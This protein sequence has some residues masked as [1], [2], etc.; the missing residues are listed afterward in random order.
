M[1]VCERALNAAGRHSVQGKMLQERQADWSRWRAGMFAPGC[2]PKLQAELRTKVAE[3]QAA[4]GAAAQPQAATLQQRASA[5]LWHPNP[6]ASALQSACSMSCP[7]AA[8]GL[9]PARIVPFPQ[10][11]T[12]GDAPTAWRV[13]RQRHTRLGCH[14]NTSMVTRGGSW[15][16][17]Q[18]RGSLPNPCRVRRRAASRTMPPPSTHAA[19]THRR[20]RTW[21][22]RAPRR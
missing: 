16:H 9:G 3:H 18:Q 8:M 5:I 6:S 22:R 13:L 20:C 4:G 7:A 11:L 17:H 2:A 1:K 19:P 15:L 10:Q 12:V 14:S 21:S